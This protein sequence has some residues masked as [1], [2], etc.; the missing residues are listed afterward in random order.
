MAIEVQDTLLLVPKRTN[1]FEVV[2]FL[3]P[4]IFGSMD[5]VDDGLPNEHRVISP[6]L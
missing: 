2:N 4:L 3:S 5:C 6:T 1:A